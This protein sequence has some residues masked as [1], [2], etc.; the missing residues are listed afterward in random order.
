MD[1]LQGGSDPLLKSIP[2]VSNDFG[3]EPEIAIKLSKR[4]AR[5]LRFRSVI[6]DAPIAKGKKSTGAMG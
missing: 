2:I 1:L 4:E 5:Y 3:I 6:S